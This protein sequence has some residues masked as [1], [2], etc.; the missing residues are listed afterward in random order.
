MMHDARWPED[1]EERINKDRIMTTIRSGDF[2]VRVLYL[3][4]KYI[5]HHQE[6]LEC[7]KL[8]NS[9]FFPLLFM[10]MCVS[11]FYHV[12]VPFAILHNKKLGLTLIL[13]QYEACAITELLLF[14]LAGQTLINKS[15]ELH[16][17]IFGSPWYMCDVNYQ[18]YILMVIMR[19]GRT[20]CVSV[21][22]LVPMSLAMFLWMMKTAFSYLAVLRQ[23]TD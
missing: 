3:L 22:K 23:V 8:M 20:T 17:N 13:V 21:G 2:K 5:K 10:K 9:Y 16:R 19:T 7:C 18:K 12:F 11:M 6:I 4:T 1:T 15:E 14:T